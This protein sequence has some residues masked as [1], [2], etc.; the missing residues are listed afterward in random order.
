MTDTIGKREQFQHKLDTLSITGKPV[1]YKAE[2]DG[3]FN[4]HLGNANL[5]K[6]PPVAKFCGRTVEFHHLGL[7]NVEIDDKS[8][9]TAYHIPQGC[10]L[11]Y[12]PCDPSLKTK[13]GRAQISTLDIAPVILKN[14]FIQT[15]GYMKRSSSV[16]NFYSRATHP[17]SHDALPTDALS[18]V[19]RY[20]DSGDPHARRS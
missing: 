5:Y 17:L 18:S 2:A 1:S 16:S 10:L 15:P 20:G 8:S 14:F 3:F 13:M 4:I 6:E 19:P 11:I 7:E 9:T 12:D